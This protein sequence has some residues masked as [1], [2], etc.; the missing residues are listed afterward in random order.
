M[1]Y[2][3]GNW[4]DIGEKIGA[5][6]AGKMTG[7]E[8]KEKMLADELALKGSE[9]EYQ[10]GQ[11]EIKNFA[12]FGGLPPEDV[13]RGSKQASAGFLED[14][15]LVSL[16]FKAA[17]RNYVMKPEPGYQPK[18]PIDKGADTAFK[19]YQEFLSGKR[20][21][22]LSVEDR[23]ALIEAQGEQTRQNKATP[24]AGIPKDD[25]LRKLQAAEKT[26][27]ARQKYGED[28]DQPLSDVRN[29]ILEAT[30]Q[31]SVDDS[32]PQRPGKS[33]GDFIPGVE[34]D[35]EKWDRLFGKMYPEQKSQSQTAK[36]K[37]GRDIVLNASTGK[38]E[39][40]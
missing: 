5:R 2:N 23:L 6:L 1:P 9:L 15:D 24:S 32:I 22:G 33:A 29:K 13:M 30:G 18:A 34:G 39:Y 12:L 8:R 19:K 36:D 4:G 16:Q 38:W 35:Q 37:S 14:A 7:S 21:K 20:A 40:K 31:P 25:T 17:P 11:D 10:R 28:V 3:F 26:L 27:V